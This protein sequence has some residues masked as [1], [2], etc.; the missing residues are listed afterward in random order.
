[1]PENK[2]HCKARKKR[3]GFTC[4]RTKDIERHVRKEEGL[5]AGEQK[6]L[7]GT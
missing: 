6:T 4:R 1:M 2:R 3:E 5:R 7:K